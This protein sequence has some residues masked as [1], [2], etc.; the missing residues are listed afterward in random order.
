MT[1]QQLSCIALGLGLLGAVAATGWANYDDDEEQISIDKVPAKARA[2]LLKHAKGAKF[3]EVER[4][5]VRGVVFYEAEWKVDGR[6]HE[7]K[8]TADGSLVELE[9][10][11]DAQSVP[12]AVRKAASQ[13]FP[14]S[15]KLTFEKKMIVLYEVEAKVDGKEREVLISPSGQVHDEHD[16]DDDD[17]DDDHDHDDDHDRDRNHDHDHAHDH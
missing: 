15:A 13:A 3:T 14:K 8:V 7:V 2:A 11:V 17:D 5:K 4:E 16:D 12:A 10:E 9:E 6:E 1:K